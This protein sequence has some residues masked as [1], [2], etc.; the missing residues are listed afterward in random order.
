MAANKVLID[1]V[2]L[3]TVLADLFSDTTNV[4]TRIVGFVVTNDGVG[5]VTYDLHIVPSGGTADATNRIIKAR[6]LLASES[7]TPAEPINELVPDGGSIE[8]KASANTSIAVR[9]SGIQFPV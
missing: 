1:G 2:Q 9:A 8:M 5:A 3:T 4:L 6:T 7:D